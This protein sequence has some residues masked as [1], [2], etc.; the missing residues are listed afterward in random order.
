MILLFC[1]IAFGNTNLDHLEH[2]ATTLK[3]HLQALQSYSSISQSQNIPVAS[4]LS[5]SEDVEIEI[6]KIQK[7]INQMDKRLK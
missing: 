2:T 3:L 4:I 6:K 1:L 5:V 7:Q